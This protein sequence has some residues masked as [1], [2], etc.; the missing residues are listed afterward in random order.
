MPYTGTK[1]PALQRNKPMDAAPRKPKKK[2]APAK[3][4]KIAGP[5]KKANPMDNMIGKKVSKF[6][7]KQT[8]T[9]RATIKDKAKQGYNSKLDESLGSRRGA[10]S[11]KSQSMS[12]RR[13]ESKGMSKSAGRGAYSAV[14]T[15]DKMKR[16]KAKG[17][18]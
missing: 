15:M 10:E 4:K 16:K 12:S 6:R 1:R 17:A 5:A 8:D 13:N 18:Y 9:K 3:R 14:T 11:T 7:K 2:T